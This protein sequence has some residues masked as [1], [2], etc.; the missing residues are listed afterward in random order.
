MGAPVGRPETP[1]TG[2]VAVGRWAY[3]NDARPPRIAAVATT[4]LIFIAALATNELLPSALTNLELVVEA[5]KWYPLSN[6]VTRSTAMK[7][8]TE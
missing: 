5:C 6:S 4:R 2:Q 3:A 8:R 7:N 1:C